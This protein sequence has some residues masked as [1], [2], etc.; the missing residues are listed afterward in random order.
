MRAP[1]TKSILCEIHAPRASEAGALAEI[2][3]NLAR[4]VGQPLTVKTLA[5]GGQAATREPVLTLHLPVELAASQHQ[6]WCL[7]CQLACFCP[8]ARISVLVQGEATFD[9]PQHTRER[10]HSA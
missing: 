8:F 4:D 6:I 3:A 1:T 2:A 9:L 10:K 7:A 5:L